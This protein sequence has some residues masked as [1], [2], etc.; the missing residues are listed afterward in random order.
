MNDAAELGEV[1][2]GS[3]VSNLRPTDGRPTPTHLAN[4]R[5]TSGFDR[6]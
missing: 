1:H 4:P 3:K 2:P 5:T 6:R